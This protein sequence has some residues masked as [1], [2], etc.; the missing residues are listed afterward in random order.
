M[1]DHGMRPD[2]VAELP[3][4]P[5]VFSILLALADGE[6]H[7]YAIMQETGRRADGSPRIGPGTLYS[8]IRRMLADGMIEE[9]SSRPDPA[10]DDAR[11]RY[12]RL[13]RYGQEVARAEAARL[14]RLVRRARSTRLLGEPG[15]ELR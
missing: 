14:D 3:L 13:T 4:S 6:Q 2:P 10:R 8:A 1:A 5:A 15:L 7:G 9:T 12:Y 11:R